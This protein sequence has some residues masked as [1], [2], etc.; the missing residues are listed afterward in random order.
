MLLFNIGDDYLISLK[1]PDE[2]EIEVIQGNCSYYEPEFILFSH[3]DSTM[4]IFT[5]SGG[6][7]KTIKIIGASSSGVSSDSSVSDHHQAHLRFL[8]AKGD[9]YLGFGCKKFCYFKKNSDGDYVEHSSTS[10][11]DFANVLIIEGEYL[12]MIKNQNNSYP[13]GFYI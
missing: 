10:T 3:S 1:D 4:R 7:K 12:Y 5:K 8:I 13:S 11:I 2:K 6:I 9:D